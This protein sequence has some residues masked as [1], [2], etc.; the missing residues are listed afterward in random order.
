LRFYIELA[1]TLHMT[2]GQLFAN[3]SSQ[4]LGLW[5]ALYRLE[6]EEQKLSDLAAKADAARRKR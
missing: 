5:T 2:M 6:H 4:E 1:R 3:A